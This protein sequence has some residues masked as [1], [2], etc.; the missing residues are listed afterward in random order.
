MTRQAKQHHKKRNTRRGKAKQCTN[1][2]PKE[3]WM[4][5]PLVISMLE[6]PRPSA[7]IRRQSVVELQAT[8][9]VELQHDGRD[10]YQCLVVRTQAARG[11]LTLTSGE[12]FTCSKWKFV[13][14]R[15]GFGNTVLMIAKGHPADK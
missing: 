5:Q 1:S 8:C 12:Q 9:L 14:L 2:A 4:N 15:G 6:Q 10:R 3:T 7:A 13:P 11:L